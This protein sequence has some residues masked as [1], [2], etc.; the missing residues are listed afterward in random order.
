MSVYELNSSV[1][2][3]GDEYMEYTQDCMMLNLIPTRMLGEEVVWSSI[4]YTEGISA[5]VKDGVAN[6]FYGL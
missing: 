2:A 5:E 4:F 1:D 3:V 6:S